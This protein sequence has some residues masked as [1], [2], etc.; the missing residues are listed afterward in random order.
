MTSVN[1]SLPDEL[2]Q[3]VSQQALIGGF[4]GESQYIE[5]LITRAKRGSERLESLLLAGLDSGEPNLLDGKLRERLRQQV[6]N[7]LAE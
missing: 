4:A 5:E 2:G 3:F 1:L 7:S 6:K